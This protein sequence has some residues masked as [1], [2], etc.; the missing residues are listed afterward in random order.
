MTLAFITDNGFSYYKGEYYYTNANIQHILTARKF[1]EKI[2]FVARKN[3]F[4]NMKNKL[5]VNDEVYLIQNVKS[6]KGIFELNKILKEVIKKS[7]AV[8]C[9]GINGFFAY[10]IAKKMKKTVISYVG[11]SVFDTLTSMKSIK[12]KLIAPFIHLMIK[13]EVKYSD[14][15]H[16]VDSYLIKQYPTNGKV[17]VCPSVVIEVKNK[18]LIL[19]YRKNLY[20]DISSRTIKFGIIGYVNN[21]IKGIDLAIK[22]LASLKIDFEL[23]IVGRG[24]H[25]WLNDLLKKEEVENKVKFLG[26]IENRQ[27]LFKWLDSLDIYLQPSRTEGMPRAT[28]EAM[29]RGLPVISSNAGGLKALINENYIFNNGNYKDFANKINLLIKDTNNL[30]N[31]SK[32]NLEVAERYDKKILDEKRDK[33]YKAIYDS[34]QSKKF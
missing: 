19:Q 6:L 1:Y 21:N 28:L 32:R 31:E 7:D 26:V 34:L 29:S 20:N 8:L 17:L 9:F 25:D 11:G 13:N 24:N 4:D 5:S 12:K 15:V 3:N 30:L 33:F 2:I 23:E 22:A 10:K 18:S 16:Y 27:K 14:Y